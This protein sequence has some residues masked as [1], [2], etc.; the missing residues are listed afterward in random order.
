MFLEDPNRPTPKK[1]R[2]KMAHYQLLDGILYKKDNFELYLMCLDKSK[3]YLAML[4]V[5]EGNSG[6]HQ[7]V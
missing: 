5:H 3:A 2:M 6:V 1:V 4:E 7:A